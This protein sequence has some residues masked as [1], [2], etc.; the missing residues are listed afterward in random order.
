MKCKMLI[1]KR[2]YTKIYEDYEKSLFSKY[3]RKDW[4]T[5]LIDTDS[6][7]Y[8]LLRNSIEEMFYRTSG[9]L[10]G[11]EFENCYLLSKEA[12]KKQIQ[13]SI[14]KNQLCF[15]EINTKN[16]DEILRKCK[17][18]LISNLHNLF[19]A[20]RLINVI[21]LHY[22]LMDDVCQNY[23]IDFNILDLRK[24]LKNNEQKVIN[25]LIMLVENYEINFIEIYD[26]SEKL[27]IDLFSL[28]NSNI[29]N[30]YMS[31]S[32]KKDNQVIINFESEVA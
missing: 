22:W 8:E 27:D 20:N 12:L 9:Y 30:E 11:L 17:S 24:I 25:S 13:K 4:V 2:N 6:L 10:Q 7:V 18:R 1:P 19:D 14:R 16:N 31:F 15:F 3:E 29:I 28:L 26:L 23:E 21:N 5:Q 32:K